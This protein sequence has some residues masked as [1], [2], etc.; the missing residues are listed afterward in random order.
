M[1]DDQLELRLR[2]WYHAEIPA[3]ET[4]PT[5]LRASLAAIAAAPTTS[6]R[7]SNRRP[8]TLLAAAALLTTALVGGALLAGSDRDDSSTV[9]LTPDATSVATLPPSVVPTSTPASGLVAY[10][11]YVPRKSVSGCT[12][13]N[14]SWF[15]SGS[16]RPDACYRLWVSNAD[17]TG[18]HE[19]LPDQSG[20]Q[21]PVAWSPDGTRLLFEGFFGPY[22]TDPSGSLEELRRD[23]KY[24]CGGMEG[25]AFSPDGSRLAFVMNSPEGTDSVVLATMGLAT[26]QVTQLATTDIAVAA[27]GIGAPQWSPD[28]T[29]LLFTRGGVHPTD[30]ATLAVVDADGSDLH[31]LGPTDLFPTDPQ[32]SPDGSLIAFFSYV[33]EDQFGG[34]DDI[35]VVRSDGT[36]LRRLT[37][38]GISLAPH[39]TADGRLVFRRLPGLGSPAGLT[40]YEA[41]IMDSDGGNLTEL[42]VGDLAQLSA[43]N[44]LVC[45]YLPDPAYPFIDDAI[46]QPVP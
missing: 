33:F 23:C 44:C 13:G 11:K 27:G 37:T 9:V 4:A 35:Y 7:L 15:P 39:W 41:W 34:T 16:P 19:L 8:L 1:T 24:P 29:R 45:P 28:G 18:A 17:G 30:P 5:D 31:D 26:R 20:W 40:G 21:T 36:D 10:R 2:D 14:I 3:D 6:R 46:W 32:W 12:P 43:A 25:F 22:L 38:D 42:Q